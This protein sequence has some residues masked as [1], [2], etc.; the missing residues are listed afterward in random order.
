M[1]RLLVAMV[2]IVPL[3]IAVLAP[4]CRRTKP[5][6]CGLNATAYKFGI[7]QEGEDH[8]ELVH[9]ILAL[10]ERA[11]TIPPE[12]RVRTCQS[13]W[14]SVIAEGHCVR[15]VEKYC[16]SKCQSPEQLEECI[17]DDSGAHKRCLRESLGPFKRAYRMCGEL[18]LEGRNLKVID[19]SLLPPP[20]EDAEEEAEKDNPEVPTPPAKASGDSE[21]EPP[22]AEED[23]PVPAEGSE[24]DEEGES[25]SEGG[26][27]DE[28]PTPPKTL[29]PTESNPEPQPVL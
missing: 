27:D 11:A 4:G 2:V 23:A 28:S 16:K 5:D 17:D 6:I 3:L 25:D 1:R 18:V 15:Q 12:E 19:R 7:N 21:P 8:E 13:D 22:A 26:D 9:S 14:A 10:E 29:D 24:A 20:P